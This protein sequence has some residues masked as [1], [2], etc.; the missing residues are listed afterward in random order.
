[1][2]KFKE[3]D[4]VVIN[5]YHEHINGTVEGFSPNYH[6]VTDEESGEIENLYEKLH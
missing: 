1:M 5:K 2:G 4:R 6:V 3:N